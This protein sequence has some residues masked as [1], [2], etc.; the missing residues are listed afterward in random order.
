ML[1]AAEPE[2]LLRIV[3]LSACTIVFVF[4]AVAVVNLLT[5]VFF[6]YA[7]VPSETSLT[8][9]L[10]ARSMVKPLVLDPE[11]E[12]ILLAASAIPAGPP[13]AAAPAAFALSAKL[14]NDGSLIEA[15]TAAD[16]IR[17][18]VVALIVRLSALTEPLPP[19]LPANGSLLLNGPGRMSEWLSPI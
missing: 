18:E 12:L 17:P 16:V 9:E 5:D 15:A 10:P 13:V 8:D 14:D 19:P 2:P 11:P 4:T 6:I 3:S 1:A 7:L